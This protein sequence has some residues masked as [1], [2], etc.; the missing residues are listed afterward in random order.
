MKHYI[1]P[2]KIL[3]LLYLFVSCKEIE[4][5]REAK[6][7]TDSTSNITTNS[8]IVHSQIS[9]LGEGILSYGHCW[10][11]IASPIISD[12]SD[13]YGIPQKEG[14]F[15]SVISKLQPNTQY[16]VRSYAKYNGGICY[17]K[18][19][20]FKTSSLGAPFVE[21]GEVRK[22]EMDLLIIRSNILDLGAGTD[23]IIQ[24]G[25]CWSLSGDPTIQDSF[26]N[27]GG[28]KSLGH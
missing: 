13:N 22:K 7:E 15:Q 25:H 28:Q 6:V 24:Y 19:L 27:L 12:L 3:F 8:V 9:D 17:G 18:E 11:S 23:S 5:K 20:Q 1:F 26:S 14:Y 16:F 4:L 21:T 2:L 10:D